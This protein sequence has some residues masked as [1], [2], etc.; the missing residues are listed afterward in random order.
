MKDCIVSTNQ[1]T[2]YCKMNWCIGDKMKTRIEG[3]CKIAF[4]NA[5]CVSPSHVD[6]IVRE[7]KNF[8]AHSAR[9]FTDRTVVDDFLLK[10][11]RRIAAS[12]G[13]HLTKKQ[14]AAAKLTNSPAVLTAYGWMANYFELVGDM[15]PNL[16]GEIHLEPIHIVEI[17]DEYFDDM[18]AADMYSVRVDTFASIWKNCFSHVK[19]RE[20][21]AV[22]GKCQCCANLS[23]LRRTFKGEQDRQRV[24]MM[25]A[26]H[27]ST[28]M[29][30]RI[31]Y[32]ERR[33]KAVMMKSKYMSVIADGMA[34]GHNML[35]H[36]GNQNTWNDGLPQHL[37]GILNHNRGM[38]VYRTFHNIKNCANVAIYTFLDMMER[39]IAEEG[40]L[41]D[42]VFHQIDGGSENTAYAWFALCELIVAKRL[43]KKLVLTRLKAG[44]THED[45]DSKFG[46]L[47]KSIRNKNV[48]TPQQY[49]LRIEKALS[50][51]LHKCKVIDVFAVPDFKTL[52]DG[53]VDPMLNACT[54]MEKTQH[55]WTFEAVTPD[56]NFVNGVRVF[57]RAYAAD[58][59]V[60]IIEDSSKQCGIDAKECD[61]FDFP[62]KDVEKGIMVDG[63]TLLTSMPTEMPA[64]L[65][66]I[67]GS[68]ELLDTLILKVRAEFQTCHPSV[69][70]EWVDWAKEDAPASDSVEEYLQRKPLHIPLGDI[71]FNGAPVDR[72]VVPEDV[73]GIASNLQ[74]MRTTDVAKWT[75]WNF[76]REDHSVENFARVESYQDADGR[77]AYRNALPPKVVLFRSWKKRKNTKHDE[78]G[79]FKFLL[80]RADRKNIHSALTSQGQMI[81]LLGGGCRVYWK[82]K[83][84]AEEFPADNPDKT[85]A[86]FLDIGWFCFGRIEPPPDGVGTVGVAVFHNAAG[87]TIAGGKDPPAAALGVAPPA[88]V[89][90]AP[91][92]AKKSSQ[93]KKRRRKVV[94][95][96]DERW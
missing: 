70:Q 5:H 55:Q 39:V 69:V 65:P 26:L 96:D 11:L 94:L 66:F 61:V 50:T 14:V 34:Q 80:G 84:A 16:D 43:C 27:R 45:I 12:Y 95:S 6:T 13:L 29:G 40:K 92:L 85:F 3:V 48:L 42:T 89:E 31:S 75:R 35:P 22:A 37:Q 7:V 91:P 60:E 87:H 30:E 86:S 88:A 51:K 19:I 20:F 57:Y 44:H 8:T 59:V 53:H 93:K 68:R 71:L 77:T 15:A 46:T 4:C 82:N 54:K 2:G 25:H 74:R 24:T 23:H 33:N 38:S 78:V 81:G 58:K 18:V 79:D 21:K 47:W 28:Y 49:K 17:Y 56:E 62:M 64:P 36:F 10:D 76:P 9:T 83:K 1:E 52:L 41:P 63:M 73:T 32:A 67:Q 90:V 72:T